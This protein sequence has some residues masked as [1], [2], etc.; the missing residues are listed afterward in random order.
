M[1]IIENSS[2]NLENQL[3]Q[4]KMNNYILEEENSLLRQS[5]EGM[6]IEIENTRNEQKEVQRQKEEIEKQ[7]E[8]IDKIMSGK[9]Y[10]ILRKIKRG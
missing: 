4:V 6:L 5:I 7:R 10:K 1:N 8:Y 3:K 9:I 2:Q